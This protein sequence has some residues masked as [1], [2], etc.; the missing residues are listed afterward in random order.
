MKIKYI[1]SQLLLIL[2]LTGWIKFF[3]PVYEI[4]KIFL[5]VLIMMSVFYLIVHFLYVLLISNPAKKE[6]IN[7]L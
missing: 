6:R 3:F 1:P 2:S 4:E 5:N 7:K